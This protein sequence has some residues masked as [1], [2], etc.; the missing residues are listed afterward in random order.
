MD[1]DRMTYKQLDQLLI[2][3]GFTRAHVE[4]KWLRYE[5]APSGTMIVLVDKKPIEMVRITDAAGAR[6][7]LVTKGLISEEELQ[8]FLLQSANGKKSVTAKQG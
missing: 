2:E 7:H 3:L 8:R 6:L 1:L 5:H 4:P